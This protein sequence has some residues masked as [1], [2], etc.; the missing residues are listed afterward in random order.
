MN[1]YPQTTTVIEDHTDNVGKAKYNTTLWQKRADS[2]W[3]LFCLSAV[4]EILI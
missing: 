1:K 2:I 4:F 3:D